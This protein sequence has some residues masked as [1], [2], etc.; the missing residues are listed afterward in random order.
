MRS[1]GSLDHMLTKQ[2]VL[3]SSTAP[4]KMSWHRRR[5]SRPP[6]TTWVGNRIL[7]RCDRTG[8]I[9]RSDLVLESKFAGGEKQTTH[10]IVVGRVDSS[11]AGRL[12]ISCA[13]GRL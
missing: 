6:L 4:S 2:P 12:P 1:F 5:M 13:D 10:D 8:N 3:S 9:G 11:A 7:P